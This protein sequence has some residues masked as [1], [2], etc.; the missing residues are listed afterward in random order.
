[1]EISIVGNQGGLA[2]SPT[3]PPLLAKIPVTAHNLGDTSARV[4]YLFTADGKTAI[5]AGALEWDAQKDAHVGFLTTWTEEASAYVDD[6][7]TLRP[8]GSLQVAKYNEDGSLT[9]DIIIP[10]RCLISNILSTP[11][12]APST[13]YLTQ[14]M[15]ADLQERLDAA[16]TLGNTKT[17][18]N[19]IL[20]ILTG[21]TP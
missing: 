12:P 9:P 11:P 18:I 4:I 17:I 3:C 19:E 2:L 13:T 21:V 20:A 7:A 14:S 16:D 6:A 15:F 1:M 5:G 8:R 10:V